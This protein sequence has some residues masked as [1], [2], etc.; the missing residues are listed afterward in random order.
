MK[1]ALEIAYKKTLPKSYLDFL[2]TADV[3]EVIVNE[4]DYEDKYDNRY[5]AVLTESELLE[6]MEM[7]DVGKARNFE[8]L[9][10]YLQLFKE[11]TESD[12]VESAH[13]DI[14]ISRVENGF[15]FAEENGDYLY[16]DPADNYSIWI[17]YHD[18]SDVKR[19]GD[20]FATI[21]EFQ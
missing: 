16:F 15:V 9:R 12:F 4:H 19:V 1:H 11:F 17:Y 20:S 21:L 6:I 13:D 5:W 2:A 14:A 7:K 18:G 8:C 10:L 3:L